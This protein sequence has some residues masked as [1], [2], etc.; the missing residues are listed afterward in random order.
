[1]F[2][3]A[4]M[5]A[6]RNISLTDVLVEAHSTKDK[7]DKHKWH[8]SKGVLSVTGQKFFN[9]NTQTGGGGAIDLSIHLFDFDVKT[10]VNWLE[11]RFSIVTQPVKFLPFENQRSFKPPPRENNKLPQVIQYLHQERCI[12]LDLLHSLISTGKLYGDRKG[13]AVFL[14]L[15]KEKKIVG[16]ELRGTSKCRW[17]GMAKGSRKDLGA[18]YVKAPNPKM[19]VICESAIDAISLFAILNESMVISTAGV[20]S[21]PTWLTEFLVK[22]DYEIFCGF[23]SDETGDYFADRMIRLYPRIK[24]LRPQSHDW[25]EVLKSRVSFVSEPLPTE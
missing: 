17:L 10:S 13:N 18:F 7:N 6:L 16:A 25:N 2:E 24:R 12:P 1:M 22:R 19:A 3:K 21:N 20:N 14:L 15:G 8:T 23:D 5:E 4:K 11:K 9:W